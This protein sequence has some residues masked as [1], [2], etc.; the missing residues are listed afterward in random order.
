[1]ITKRDKLLN[2]HIDDFNNNGVTPDY[3]DTDVVLLGGLKNERQI[4]AVKLGINIFATCTSGKS[5]FSI[6]GHF[7]QLQAGETLI[8]P[9]SAIVT[10][11]LTS[12]DF[13]CVVLGITDHLLAASLRSYVNM[14][15]KAV[16]IH[17]VNVVRY[18]M[19]K[20]PREALVTV[21]RHFL[22]HDDVIYRREIIHALLQALLLNLCS[23]IS[24]Q[25]GGISDADDD[26]ESGLD[27]FGRFIS[28]LSHADVKRQSVKH[29]ANRLFITPKYLS[30]VCKTAS[31]KTAGE[32]V[33]EYVNQ[34]INYY[35]TATTMAL[36]EVA[37]RC[38]F[39]NPSAFGKYVRQ[40]FGQSP[41]SYRKRVRMT[42]T[43]K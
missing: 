27:I 19:P 30:R 41:H 11:V 37:A 24:E 6:N 21:L 33:Q 17:K 28:M 34:D 29:Y 16:Y 23:I 20:Q 7:V 38:G 32:W 3:I 42:D 1:M 31:G 5:Q 43:D 22:E 36:K 25:S 10:D 18:K 12:H 40:H 13:E 2:V 35:L 26:T 4:N 8:C 9:S 15:N 39:P 14:W